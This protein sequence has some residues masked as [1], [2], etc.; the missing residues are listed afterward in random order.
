MGNARKRSAAWLA[1]ALHFGDVG[2]RFAAPPVDGDAAA[3]DKVVAI[4]ASSPSGAYRGLLFGNDPIFF[5]SL[6]MHERRDKQR[7]KST[8]KQKAR[9]PAEKVQNRKSRG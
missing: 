2:S 4:D 7:P 1:D 8:P 6:E 9:C 5:C 3:A